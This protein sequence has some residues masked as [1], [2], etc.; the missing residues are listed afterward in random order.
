MNTGNKFMSAMDARLGET[1]ARARRAQ[2]RAAR[3][4]APNVVMYRRV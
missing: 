2:E 1:I 3:G 4:A